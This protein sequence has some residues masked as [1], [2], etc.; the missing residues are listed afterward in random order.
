MA[1]YRRLLPGIAFAVTGSLMLGACSSG[2]SSGGATTITVMWQSSELSKAQIAT[3]EKL[4]PG[5]KVNFVEYDEARFNAM[6]TAGDPPDVVRG[7]PSDN[8]FARGLVAPLDSYIAKSSVIKADDLVPAEDVWKWNG[9]ARGTGPIYGILKDFSPDT[10][11]WENNSLFQ[12]AG[13][14]PFST[15]QPSSWD[16]VLSQATQ[17]KT[18]GV[19][20]PL[21]IEWQWGIVDEIYE[22]VAQQGASV[23]SSDLSH[24]DFTTPEAQRA[25][26]WL[27]DY[28]KAG[29][30]PTSLD[31]LAAGQDA[32]AYISGSMAMSLDGYWFGGNLESNAA[33]A[34]KE[35]QLVPAPTYGKRISMIFGGVG[36]F[37]PSGSKHKDAAWKFLEYYSG[38]QP[39]IDRAKT[40]WGLPVLKSLWSDLP[41]GLAYQ[42]QAY[43]AALAEMN[44][45]AAPPDSP[46]AT[47]GQINPI[48]DKE[49]QSVIQGKQS[50][51]QAGQHINSQV[52]TLLA[53]G[54]AQL[55]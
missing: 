25:M 45:V 36:G 17:L 24:V 33:A 4:N 46:Y 35:S 34:Q 38:G 30:G 18:K 14:T 53:Q 10:T 55:G 12:Q 21:G 2:G 13:V 15:T 37:I 31:P 43:N 40:G 16:A 47:F 48:V 44:Y 9:K 51:M 20:Y 29:D 42:K 54:K 49:L 52:N 1:R 7:S 19:K 3:F 32:P 26:R 11:I 39:A 8:L 23:F 41:T 5:I 28:A 27:V 6:L 50:A 22:M